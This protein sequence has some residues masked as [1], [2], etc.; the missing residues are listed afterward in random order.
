MNRGKRVLRHGWDGFLM[1]KGICTKDRR[2]W[3]VG[4]R[5]KTELK[6]VGVNKGV[7]MMTKGI[8]K[9]RMKNR[10][11]E[12]NE[13][14]KGFVRKTSVRKGRKKRVGRLNR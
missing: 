1:R 5:V 14:R 8:G 6:D 3:K 11:A 12:W 13:M 7:C 9:K 2:C 4:K 10:E